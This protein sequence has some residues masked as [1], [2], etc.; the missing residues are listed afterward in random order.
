[1]SKQPSGMRGNGPGFAQGMSLAFEFA[2]AVFL[3]WLAGR[4]VDNRFDT[5][6]W[7]QVVGALIGWL[8]GFLHVYYRSKGVDWQGVPGTRR[9][10]AGSAPKADAG[11]KAAAGAEDKGAGGGGGN[12]ADDGDGLGGQR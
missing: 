1:M 8:G 3:F 6:P 9:P 12:R 2:G 10:A 4:F 11:R 5:E 7:F